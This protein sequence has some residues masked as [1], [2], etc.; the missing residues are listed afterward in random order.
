MGRVMN[1]TNLAER[2]ED[3]NF[4]EW[5]YIALETAKVYELTKRKTEQLYNSSTAKLIAKIPFTAGCKNPER[6]AIA[7]LVLYEAEIKGFQKY[8]AHLPSDDED[9]FNRLAFISTFEGGN[10]AIIEHG[11]NML[12]YI[13][14]EEYNRSKEKYLKNGIYN[15][16]ASG[17]WNYLQLKKK[18][19]RKIDEIECPDLDRYFMP[20]K[21]YW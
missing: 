17:K 2:F 1:T 9:I 21:A 4:K 10:S 18:L 16:I 14:V 15:P 7:H 8:C 20:I 3:E 5:N 11:M 13:M 19:K 6:T 12:A